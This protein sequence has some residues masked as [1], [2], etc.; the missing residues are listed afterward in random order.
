MLVVLE[1]SRHGAE[2]NDVEVFQEAI[3][4]FLEQYR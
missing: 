1:N 3:K 4:A 2:N